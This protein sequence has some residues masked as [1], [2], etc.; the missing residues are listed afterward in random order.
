MG[1]IRGYLRRAFA[2]LTAMTALATLVLLTFAAGAAADTGNIVEESD[3]DDPQ[4]GSGWQAGTCKSE[5]PTSAAFCSIATPNQFFEQAAGHP[6]WGFTQ[7]IVKHETTEVAGLKSE[8]PLGELKTVRVDLPVGLSVN[9][10]AT[11]QCPLATFETSPG[12]CAGSEVGQSLVWG[13]TIANIE[14][15]IPPATVYNLVPKQGEPALFG[16]ELIGND[17]FLAA[18]IDWAGDYHEGF[19][20]AVPQAPLPNLILKNRL[21]FN[22]RS[23]DGTFITT[24][25]TCLGPPTVAPWE[26]SYSTWLRADSYGEPNPNFPVGSTKFESPIPDFTHPKECGSIPFEPGIST[27]PGTEQ[28]DSPAAATVDV[29]LPEEIPTPSEK[30]EVTT[31]QA[32]SHVK[33]AT[34]TLPPGLNLNPSAANGLVACTDEQFGKGTRNPVACPDASRIGTVSIETPPLPPDSLAGNVYVGEQRSDDPASGDLFRIFVAAES[35]RYGISARLIGN[36]AANPQ[37]GKLSTTFAD[38]PQVPFSSFELS[39]DGGP[40]AALSSPFTCGPHETA[41]SM[42]PWSSVAGSIPP[43]QEG[44]SNDEPPATPADQFTLTKAPGGGDCPAGLGDR[45]FAPDFLAGRS[46]FQAGAFTTVTNTFGRDDGEQELKGAEVNLPPGLSAKLKGLEYCPEASLAAA[47][48]NSGRAEA[49]APGCPASSLV[50]GAMVTAGTGP[51]P[52]TIEGK[53]FLTGPYNGAPLSLAIVTPATAGPYDLGSVVV[54]VALFV[55]RSTGQ[56]TA[57]SDPIPHVFGG[58]RLD[59]RSVI[60][61]LDRP[62]F[63]VNPTN[64][65]QKSVEGTARGGG[66]NP[67]DPAA[68][69]S[70]SRTFPFLLEGCEALGFAPNLS[71]RLSGAMRR[72]KNPKLSAVLTARPGDANIGNAVVTLPKGL[73]LDQASI[74]RVCTRVQFAANACPADSVYGFARAHTPLLDEPL[75]GPVVLRSSDNPLPDLVAALRGQVDIDLVG[76]NDSVRG[77]L[78]NTF[79]AVP[80]L[81]VER[82]ELTVRGG[83]KGLLQNTRNL[84][85]KPRR[86]KGGKARK[87]RAEFVAY[88]AKKKGKKRKKRRRRPMRAVAV[89]TAQ[90]GKQARLKPKVQRS[91][92]KKKKKR[93]RRR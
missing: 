24:P 33:D 78:R 14:T 52:L 88:A 70:F 38:N 31:K 74:A 50:G 11:P 27:D 90:N 3:P 35:A 51:A 65:D 68:F 40:G 25:T 30:L 77:R 7:I 56:V 9:P 64:C 15:V 13:P 48:A 57:V 82:F 42:T 46:S 79:D 86:K 75:E 80:D 22:G 20:I 23:G 81:P 34:V 17:I 16:F 60:V 49:A 53:T 39:F 54:R 93:K 36:V 4:V 21:V 19:T 32:T 29:T 91:C 61:R 8:T 59:V 58:V 83:K 5:P 37:T 26:H 43:G 44:G 6:Q 47:A 1:T 63:S 55:D 72:T 2:G 69:T 67:A 28:T 18:D 85:P 12:S 66:A 62:E 89:F 87:R 73:L 10:Q 41:T 92:K 84:C 76:R 45:P 71:L